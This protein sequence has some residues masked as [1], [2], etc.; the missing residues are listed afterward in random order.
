MLLANVVDIFFRFFSVFSFVPWLHSPPSTVVSLL[1]PFLSVY[2]HLAVPASLSFFCF[3]NH[4][5]V[6]FTHF[7]HLFDIISHAMSSL[8]FFRASTVLPSRLSL[9]RFLC[10]RLAAGV[11]LKN[12]KVWG[13]ACACVLRWLHRRDGLAAL[14]WLLVWSPGKLYDLFS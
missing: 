1:C 5:R 13:C 8:L 4:R 9:S 6:N 3:T 7:N 10:L 14:C 12:N 11:F 2:F